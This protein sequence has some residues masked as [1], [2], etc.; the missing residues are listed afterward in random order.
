MKT[1]FAILVIVI[2]IAVAVLLLVEGQVKRVTTHTSRPQTWG[3]QVAQAAKPE[4]EWRS[5]MGA[6][7]ADE[8]SFQLYDDS[9]EQ[10]QTLLSIARPEMTI[11]I[12]GDVGDGKPLAVIHPTGRVELNAN[13]DLNEAA[14]R[15][16]QAVA[17][18]M[19]ECYKEGASWES[20]ETA[21]TAR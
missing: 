10:P 11:T 15:F 1:G 21:P 18:L 13:G 6:P 8:H 12:H 16:W 14:T 19:P 20:N 9:G 3:D 7:G 17:L 2:A 5:V 4:V